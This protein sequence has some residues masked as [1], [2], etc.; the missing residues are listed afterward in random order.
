MESR[1]GSNALSAN[2]L[3]T[4]EEIMSVEAT[5]K[6]IEVGVLVEKERFWWWRRTIVYI[7]RTGNRDQ[8]RDFCANPD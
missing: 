8:P 1:H 3:D 7:P 5:E 6:S 2:C 4:A